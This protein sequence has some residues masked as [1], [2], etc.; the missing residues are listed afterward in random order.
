MVAGFSDFDYRSFSFFLFLLFTFFGT[1]RLERDE[2]SHA[3]TI[4]NLG[5]QQLGVFFWRKNL[6]D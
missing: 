4:L 3:V 5:R 2:S 6:L 1:R